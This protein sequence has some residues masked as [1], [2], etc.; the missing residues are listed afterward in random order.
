MNPIL[1]NLDGGDNKVIESPVNIMRQGEDKNRNIQLDRQTPIQ[2]LLVWFNLCW[3][4]L[5]HVG[6]GSQG[7]I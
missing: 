4:G 7:D 2:R 3:C 1:M 5:I 6:D